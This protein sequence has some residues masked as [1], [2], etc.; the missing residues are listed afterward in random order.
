MPFGR[1]FLPLWPLDPS[2]TYLN[3]G[4]VGVVPIRVAEAQQA[5]RDRIERHPA[6]FMLRDLWSFTGSATSGPTL[7]RQ[8]AAGVAAFVGARADD[9]VFVDN[10]STGVNAV[11]RSM[12]FAPGDEILV[13]DHIY[14]GLL[15]AVHYIARRSG[16]AVRVASMPYPAFDPALAVERL[17][18]GITDRT[19]LVLVDHIAAESAIV[20]PV[21]DLVRVCKAR[22]V[23]VLV[24]GA[25]VPGQLALDVS[26]IGAD[27]YVANL[28][29]WAMAPRSSAFMVVAPERQRDLH[30]PVV[31]WGLD[32][33]FT[34]EFDWVGTRD[35]TPWLTAPEGIRFLQDLDYGALRGYNHDLAWHAARHLTDLW[36][37][38]LEIPESAIGSMVSVMTPASIGSAKPDAVRLRDRL[39]FDHNIE[40]Q[41]HA[42]AG[43]VWVRV[44]AQAY[45]DHSDIEKLGRALLG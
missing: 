10:T 8:A 39:L 36:D 5:W 38:P 30:P 14:G 12:T 23:P 28:H 20:F 17:S 16:A 15:T 43:R 21:E 9:L 40:V 37:T 25:H 26:A 18:A 19:K 2:A 13:T 42:R 41:V 34:Q 6:R 29:K 1:S 27:Y 24:D 22:G 44:S 35:P 31:S 4:T 32:T 45:N 3:H 11:L 33:G 7:M